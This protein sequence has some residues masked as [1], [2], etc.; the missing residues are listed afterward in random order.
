VVHV[1]RMLRQDGADVF[2]VRKTGQLVDLDEVLVVLGNPADPVLLRAQVLRTP[3]RLLVDRLLQ[4]HLRPLDLLWLRRLVRFV[5]L[6]RALE[7]F[8]GL[9]VFLAVA[10]LHELLLVVN[11]LHD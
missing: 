9:G 7:H 6:P 11:L 8:E 3:P 4:L 10:C 2:V 5:D 1:V